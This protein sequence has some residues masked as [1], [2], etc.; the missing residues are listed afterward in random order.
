[1]RWI[2]RRSCLCSFCF[3]FSVVLLWLYYTNREKV[4]EQHV[5]GKMLICKNRIKL[6]CTT[7]IIAQNYRSFK[8]LWHRGVCLSPYKSASLRSANRKQ[9][10]ADR[11]GLILAF[12]GGASFSKVEPL[13]R[14]IQCEP[15]GAKSNSYTVYLAT[16]INQAKSKLY[17]PQIQVRHS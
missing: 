16:A 1:M 6:Q 10:N 5:L 17:I 8:N 2:L 11:K 14:F 15:F 7:D 9:K 4:F 13:I 12:L 3:S